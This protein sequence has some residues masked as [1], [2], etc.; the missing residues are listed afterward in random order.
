MAKAAVMTGNDQPLEIRDS[1]EVEPTR[2]GE[3]KVRMS[4]SGACHSG[5]SMQNDTMMAATPIARFVIKH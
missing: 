1:L 2:A 5:L 3:I 4:A